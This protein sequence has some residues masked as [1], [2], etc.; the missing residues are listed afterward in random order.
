MKKDIQ[1]FK[2]ELKYTNVFGTIKDDDGKVVASIKRKT[3]V[4]NSDDFISSLVATDSSKKSV[5]SSLSKNKVLYNVIDSRT[6][7]VVARMD[8]KRNLYDLEGNY[9][10][11]LGNANYLN[12]YLHILTVLAIIAILLAM[13]TLKSSTSKEID[14]EIIITDTSGKTISD[15]WNVFGEYEDDKV[16][17]PEKTY[18][19]LFTVKNLND[20]PVSFVV[21][22]YEVNLNNIPMRYRLSTYD[23]YLVGSEYV[24]VTMDDLVFDPVV[25]PAQSEL[26]F[27][28][29]WKW[30]SLSDEDDTIIGNTDG[31][32][33]IINIVYTST[34][35][36]EESK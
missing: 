18:I 25:I 12:L 4:T 9:I 24:W 8:K 19:Y 28:L 15:Q 1:V 36:D 10:G 35:Y 34:I 2:R 26:T 31:A 14:S 22:F 3:V 7:T 30:K 11:T 13:M 17:Y 5:L 6:G 20:V 16:I 32:E 23:G 21:D 27:A 33:Y 29:H